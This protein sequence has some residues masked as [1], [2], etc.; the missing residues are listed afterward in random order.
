MPL[1]GMLLTAGTALAQTAASTEIPFG[2]EGDDPIYVD[3]E[4]A[5]YNGGVTLLENNVTV[6]QS[7]TTVFSD[8]MEIYRESSDTNSIAGSLRLGA[9]RRI[10]AMGNFRFENPEN[11]ITGNKGVYYADR[12]IFIVTGN[13]E[14]I[15]PSG[16][17][18]EGNRLVYNLKTRAA[19]FGSECETG[20][21]ED[22]AQCE[23][24][25]FTLE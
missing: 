20:T 9:L 24:V 23:R 6:R 13:V 12:E 5:T 11:I 22:P 17:S 21:A 19:K 16:S 18:V 10:E 2:F 15:Q 8:R 7:D 14:L 4:Q 25:T 1:I 3:A